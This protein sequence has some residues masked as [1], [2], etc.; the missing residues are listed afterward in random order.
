MSTK[1]TILWLAA[2]ATTTIAAVGLVYALTPPP[3]SAPPEPTAPPL[4]PR[5]PP[6]SRDLVAAADLRRDAAVACSAGRYEECLRLLDQA[7]EKD[8]L[9]DRAKVVRDLRESAKTRL[10]MDGAKK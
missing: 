10:E 2:A 6:E 4:P 3:S 8:P 9:G 1:R 5:E 7:K